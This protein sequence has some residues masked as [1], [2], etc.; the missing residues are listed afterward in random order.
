VFDT[1]FDFHEGVSSLGPIA[2]FVGSW[3]KPAGTSHP[4]PLNW[5]ANIAVG[6]LFV[7]H[8]SH[9]LFPPFAFFF[10]AVSSGTATK[11][12]VKSITSDVV[13]VGAGTFNT[14]KIT[15]EYLTSTGI[16]NP[17]G[18]VTVW[19]MPILGASARI[20]QNAGAGAARYDLQSFVLN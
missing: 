10:P 13:T 1:D 6:D 9:Y 17:Y 11:V 3:S 8:D 7:I 14:Q 20:E 4:H 15:F 12:R 2:A 18:Q 19:W 16:V 5:Y